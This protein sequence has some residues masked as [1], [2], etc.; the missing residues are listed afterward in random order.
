MKIQAFRGWRPVPAQAAR[1]AC[2]PYDTLET[3]EARLM[4]AGNPASFLHVVKAEIDLPEDADPH[5]EPVYAQA[6]KNWRRLRDEHIIVQDEAACLYVYRLTM[7]GHVQTGVGACCAVDDYNEGHIRRHEHTR[8]DKLTD[9]IY[10]VDALRAHSGPVFLVHPP[11]DA[12]SRLVADVTSGEPVCDFTVPGG[13]RHTLWVVSD[14]RALVDA[15]GEVQAGYIADGHHR[16][17]AAAAVSAC[18]RAGPAVGSDAYDWFLG[19]WFP[20]DQVKVLPYN[21][22]VHDLN[23]LTSEAFLERLAEHGCVTA[24]PAAPALSAGRIGIYLGGR[25]HVLTW[26]EGLAGD[27][28][29]AL[30]VSLLQDRILE[31][32]LGIVNPRK[33]GRLHFVGGIKGMVELERE[34]DAEEG[35][36]AFAMHPVRVESMMHIAD[37]GEMMPPKSTWF[38]PKLLSGL[39]V[40]GF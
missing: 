26:R 39:I 18:R 33:D 32:I 35:T 38:E 3:D 13:V 4:A 12:V 17:A 9:R 31:P 6:A 20:A 14:P 24:A 15:F 10:M 11:S 22:V 27:A 37:S 19:V 16:A 2:P 7:G 36:A 34:V 21:R 5:G 1:V 30:D 8:D 29:A 25:W 40:H 23:G 28:L